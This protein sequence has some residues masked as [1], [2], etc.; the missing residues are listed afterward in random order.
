MFDN[1]VNHNPIARWFKPYTNDF[2]TFSAGN[3]CL[4]IDEKDVY[5]PGCDCCPEKI[6]KVIEINN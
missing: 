3:F 6:W 5:V 1:Y 2:V 4:N